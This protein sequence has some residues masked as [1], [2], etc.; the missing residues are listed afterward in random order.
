MLDDNAIRTLI[1]KTRTVSVKDSRPPA[2]SDDALAL[3]FAEIHAD[4]LRHVAAWNKWLSW[5]GTHWT[6]DAT[7]AA[8]NE[9][10]KICRVAAAACNKTKLASA[11]ASSKTVAAVI[12]LARSD[13]RLAATIEQWN[14]DLWAANTPLGVIDL[15]TGEM[16]PHCVTD[17]MTKITAVAPDHNCPTPIWLTFLETVT[18][19]D[20]ELITFLQRMAGYALTGSTEEHALFFHHGIGANGKTTFIKTISS[21]FGDYHRTAPIETFTASHTEHHPTDLAGLHGARLVTSIETEEGRRW[22]EQK[23]TALTGGDEISARFMRQDYFDYTPH[24]KLVIAGNHKPGLRSINEAIRRRLHLIPWAVVIPEQE[25]DKKLVEKL[26]PEWPGILAW[27]IEG[28]LQWQKIG[29][30]PPKI[31]TEATDAYMQ[32]EDALFAW[33]DEYCILDANAWEKT[34]TLYTGW[35]AWAEKS[36]EYVGSMK[37]FSQNLEE[38]GPS[39]GV[40]YKRHMTFGRGFL[41]L[42][43]VGDAGTQGT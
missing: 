7:L 14:T 26:Q 29:L 23:I 17:Y 42:R 27:I 34:T 40:Y 16:R 4:D 32:A 31:V 33:I 9:A 6:F 39:K 30:A 21:I 25:R 28:C 37:R 18:N 3:H 20:T 41:G 12:N 8:W 11:L 13:R 38:R 5:D 10:R 19:G 35:K 24:F 2:F 15:H 43:L 22:A 36:G 1:K